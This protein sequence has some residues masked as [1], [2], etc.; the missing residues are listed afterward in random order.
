M[1]GIRMV[2]F[3]VV[4]DFVLSHWLIFIL[5]YE[6]IYRSST[7]FP[8]AS[9]NTNNMMMSS[10]VFAPTSAGVGAPTQP[11]GS[12]SST[13]PFYAPNMFDMHNMYL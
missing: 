13:S 9:T 3:R 7:S 6:Q 4:F 10:Q 5:D 11:N 2:L 8:Y 12:T 1:P